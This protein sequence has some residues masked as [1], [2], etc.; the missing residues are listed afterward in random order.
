MGV[1]ADAAGEQFVAGAVR[2]GHWHAAMFAGEANYPGAMKLCVTGDAFQQSPI[3]TG[4]GVHQKDDSRRAGHGA[5]LARRSGTESTQS[6]V[7]VQLFVVAVPLQKTAEVH[8]LRVIGTVTVAVIWVVVFVIATPLLIV[9]VPP[10][11]PTALRMSRAG[12][13]TIRDGGPRH[14][15]RPCGLE[16]GVVGRLQDHIVPAE[17]QGGKEKQE[18][19]RRGQRNSTADTPRRFA[20]NRL[21]S[22]QFPNAFMASSLA[23]ARFL[24]YWVR[25]TGMVSASAWNALCTPAGLV[26]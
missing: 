20:A 18:Q 9:T 5:L 1:P 13:L 12:R 25:M 6:E 7:S 19:D 24:A 22:A 23:I 16:S 17:F 4:E 11:M 2:L 26:T 14:D 10:E 8:R 15:A 3:V 21:R